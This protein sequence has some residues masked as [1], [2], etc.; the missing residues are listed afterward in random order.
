[1]KKFLLLLFFIAFLIPGYA[2]GAELFF[3]VNQKKIG[4]LQ[5][6]EVGVFLN[7]HNES[8]NAIEAE[9]RFPSEHMELEGFYDGNSIVNL[10]IQKPAIISNG[11]VSFSG[12]IPGGINI[13]KG[14]L[15]S[16]VFKT[17]K[18]GEAVVSTKQEKILLNDGN[19]SEAKVIKAPIIINIE[20]KKTSADFIPLYDSVAPEVF[21]PT[22]ANDPN[23]FD[24][25][26]FLIFIT[27]DKG[28]GIDHYEVMENRPV[29]SLIS[30]FSKQQWKVA[31]SPYVLQDQTFKSYIFVKA[32]DGAGNERI[33]T[34]KPQVF[35][36]YE[37][38]FIW[39][40]I[41]FIIVIFIKYELFD[42][43][44]KIILKIIR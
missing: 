12:I 22:I 35:S 11:V 36:W 9:V 5:K 24:G 37:N 17:I 26:W 6:F 27:Q 14:Y 30:L 32:V 8:I 2:H 33:A 41:I 19:G 7:T 34:V 23:L 1:M 16:I 20:D 18:A 39:V 43:I 31:E 25:K 21:E 15:F 38:Y 10:W 29:G 44:W 42:K 28:S 4:N 13:Q 40:I 3:G